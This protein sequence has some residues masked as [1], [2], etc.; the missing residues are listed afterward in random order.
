MDLYNRVRPRKFEDMYKTSDFLANISARVD[1]ALKGEPGLS[2]ALIFYS[3]LPGL[4]KTSSARILASE[5]NPDLSEKERECLFN[6]LYNPVCV[7]VNGGEKRKIDDTRELIEMIEAL[8]APMHDYHYVFIIDEVHKL[9]DDSLDAL[10]AP[11]ENIPENVYVIMTT[12]DMGKLNKSKSSGEALVSRGETHK[13]HPLAKVDTLRLLKSAAKIEGAKEPE[14]KILDTIYSES[15]GEPR[16]AIVL[17]SQYLES[18]TVGS[19]DEEEEKTPYFKQLITMYAKVVCGEKV[20]WFNN[21]APHV[22]TMLMSFGAEDIRIKLLQRLYGV[23]MFEKLSGDRG[24]Q[25]A[26][27]YERAG[28]LLRGHIEA[29]QKSELV[30]RLYSIYIE[31]VGL[32][33]ST[34]GKEDQQ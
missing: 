20:T 17:L 11:V 21:I 12:T 30:S 4:G 31:A 3:E 26:R 7:H 14:T 10:L 16:K 29:P 13:F 33:N 18:G 34:T 27:L 6:G 5:L 24:W 9:T 15:S 23:I 1:K 2:H 22:Q 28:M 19:I 25:V 32:A 8:R